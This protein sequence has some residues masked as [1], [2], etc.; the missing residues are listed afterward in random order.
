V[1]HAVNLCEVYKD[2]LVR[3]ET[4][5]KA[6]E[7]LDDLHSIGLVSREDMDSEFWKSAAQL[8]AKYKRVSLADCFA[9]V[10]ASRAHGQ[11]FSSDHHEFDPIV[12]NGICPTIFIR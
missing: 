10:L 2:C 9:L 5:E 12:N 6:D 4:Q 8:K 11:L 1:V 3:G 7:L